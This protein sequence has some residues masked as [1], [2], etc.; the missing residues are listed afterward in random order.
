MAGGPDALSFL[1]LWRFGR[2]GWI[3]P[4]WVSFLAMAV[5]SL[6]SPAPGPVS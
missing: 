3:G 1:N 4:A 5:A 6:P 2:E